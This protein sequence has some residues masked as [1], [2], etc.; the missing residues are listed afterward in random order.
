M[1]QR[2]S[3]QIIALRSRVIDK[4][5]QYEAVDIASVA[6]V[7]PRRI[8]V[9]HL[10]LQAVKQ[11]TLD[12]NLKALGFNQ[13]Q[14]AAALGNIIGSMAAPASELATHGWLNLRTFSTSCMG[15]MLGTS[16]LSIPI[17]F[18]LSLNRK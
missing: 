15:N 11:L 10:A 1:A 7:R 4:D 5:S 14:L 2:Y 3:A 12:D 18:A 17:W 6:L 13:H 16:G 8:D 9:E